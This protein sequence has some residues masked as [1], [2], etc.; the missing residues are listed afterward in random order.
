MAVPRPPHRDFLPHPRHRPLLTA[1]LAPAPAAR[2]A[3]LEW[4]DAIDFDLIDMGEQRL[5]PF[6]DSRLRELGIDHPLAGRVRGLYRRAWCVD[7]IMRNELG[8]ILETLA[9]ACPRP[10]LLKGTALGRLVYD[11]PAH[12]PSSDFDIL[13]PANAL[14]GAVAALQR[15]GG[16]A[17]HTSFHA[18]TVSMPGGRLVDLHRSP[19][20]TAF[21]ESHVAPLFTRLRRI[22]PE[23]SASRP[24]FALGNADQLLHTFM[25]GLNPS[26]CPPIRWIVD[27]ALLLRRERGQIDWDLFAH[28]AA[29]LE[30]IEPAVIGLRET[31]AFEPDDEAARVLGRLQRQTSSSAVDLWLQRRRAGGA[32]ALWEMTRRN[33]RGPGRLLLVIRSVLARHGPAG[34][35]SRLITKGPSQLLELAKGLRAA[36]RAALGPT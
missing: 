26:P 9:E 5:M 33:A 35:A 11:H 13:V 28:E 1:L 14:P 10:V 34:L 22:P 7:H 19:Y 31:L 25:H 8:G 21:R 27:A 2:T 17:Y 32:V 20:H 23:E 16:T 18:T 6:F 3:A 24:W 12:R 29:R 15:A 30:F 36:P 4:L